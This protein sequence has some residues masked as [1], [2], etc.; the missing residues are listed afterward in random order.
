MTIYLSIHLPLYMQPLMY[1][2]AYTTTKYVY[3]A[4]DVELFTEPL[5]YIPAPIA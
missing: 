3:A 4:S 2:V 5:V 1:M